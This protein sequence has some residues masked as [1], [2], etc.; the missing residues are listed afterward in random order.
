MSGFKPKAYTKYHP[1][2]GYVYCEN[3]SVSIPHERG[4]YKVVTNSDGIRSNKTYSKRNESNS[5]RILLFGDSFTAADSV[6]NEERFSDLLEEK[7]KNVEII[8]FGLSGTGTDQQFLLLRE[9]G[10]QYDFD[11]VLLCP[12]LENIRRNCARY[13]VAVDRDSEE[14]VLVPKPFFKKNNENLSLFNVPVPKTRP[15]VSE[16]DREMLAETDWGGEINTYFVREGI[17]QFLPFLKPFFLKILSFFGVSFHRDYLSPDSSGWQ[18]MAA[19][20]CEFK[21]VI[22]TRPL[23]VCPLPYYLQIE[24]YECP[25]IYFNRF[26]SLEEVGGVFILDI[27]RHF[28]SLT[29]EQKRSCRWKRDIH[30]TPFAHAVVAKGLCFELEKLNLIPKEC[31]PL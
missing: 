22:G 28:A 26:R 21:R 4:S 3:A 15:R 19:I 7:M 16:A 17:N 25:S 23:V 13:R 6:K 9:M 8:N 10:L 31:F 14:R 5:F 11:M 20:I 24:G 18:L 2:I 27:F 1:I 29:N 12:L 30:Y